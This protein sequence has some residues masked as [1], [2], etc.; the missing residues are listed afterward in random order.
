M[1][2]WRMGIVC[3]IPKATITHS[4]YVIRIAADLQ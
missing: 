4:E 1:A 2:M 3:Q